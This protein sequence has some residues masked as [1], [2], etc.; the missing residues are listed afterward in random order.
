MHIE[1]EDFNKFHKGI[2]EPKKLVYVFEHIEKCDYCAERFMNIESEDRL[3]APAYLKENIIKRT[4]ML[5]VKAQV[6]IKTT[7]KQVQLLLY[8]LK[9]TAAVLGAL[10][11]LFS[12]GQIKTTNYMEYVN[13]SKATTSLSNQLSEKSNYV[14]HVMNQYS[15]QIVNGGF[16]Q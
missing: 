3:E 5:D 7:S 10:F 8:G 11:L 16:N 2:L 1:N 13:N 15:N 4:Q 12:V 6:Q 14:V 9:T